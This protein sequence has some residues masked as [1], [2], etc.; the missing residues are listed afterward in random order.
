M[1]LCATDVMRADCNPSGNAPLSCAISCRA[2]SASRTIGAVSRSSASPALVSVHALDAAIEQ[3][4]AE[5]GLELGDLHA[6]RRLHDVELARS[7]VHVLLLGQ[8]EEILH[9]LSS[10]A[11]LCLPV[12]APRSS[13]SDDRMHNQ[14]LFV[15]MDTLACLAADDVAV[16][17]R[18]Q[19]SETRICRHA[20][21]VD[22]R[23]SGASGVTYGVRLLQLLRN[24]ASRRIL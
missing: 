4:L 18:D 2:C 1:V 7:R 11:V 5:L 3:L 17:A 12:L 20:Q 9:C 10:R 24:A 13:F 6:Q 16:R 23:H 15:L 22:H 14:S 19:G 8:T 21:A